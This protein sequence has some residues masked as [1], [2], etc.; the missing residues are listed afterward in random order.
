MKVA[1]SVFSMVRPEEDEHWR[2]LHRPGDEHMHDD[3]QSKQNQALA[4]LRTK[5]SNG[6]AR[7]G[8]NK[9]QLADRARLGRTTVWEAFRPGGPVPSASTV[10][11]LARVLQLSQDELLNLQ[12]T[13]EEAASDSVVQVVPGPGKPI[14][15]WD[16]HHLEVHPAVPVPNGYGSS[17]PRQRV[18]PGY[19]RRAHDRVLTQAVQDV[20]VGNSRTVVLVGTS[21][22]GKTRACWEAVQPLAKLGWR[23][24]HPLDPTRADAALEGLKQVRPSTVV[25]LNEAQHYLGDAAV[26]EQIA[27][28]V[29][30]L[31]TDPGRMPVLV[32]GTLWPE[33]ARRYVAL[34]SASETDLHSQVR[35]LLAGRTLHVPDSFDAKALSAASVLA[36]AGDQLLA[37]ALTRAGAHG[38]VTQDLAGAPEL[39]HAYE[40]GTP[41]ARALLEAAMDARRLGVGLHLPQTFLTDAASDYLSDTDYESLPE[42]WAEA[43]FAELARPVHG[44][45]APLRRIVVRPHRHP[46]GTQASAAQPG[47]AAGPDFRLADYL[48]QHGR[49]IRK[50]L[51]PPASFWHAG[52]THLIRPDDLY[53][54][55]KAAEDRLRL[56][57]AHHFHHRAAIA[58]HHESLMRLSGRRDLEGIWKGRQ[59]L[60]RQAVDAGDINKLL[61]LAGVWEP[62]DWDLSEALYRRAADAGSSEAMYCLAM[63]TQEWDQEGA[64]ALYRQA[65]DAGYARA[66]RQLAVMREKAGDRKNAEALARQAAD[67]GDTGDTLHYLALVRDAAGDREGAEAVYRQAADAG[68]SSTLYRLVDSAGE[69]GDQES[70][71]ALAW[72]AADAG[73]TDA[74]MYLAMKRKEAGARKSAEAL[75]RQAADAGN[76][77]AV[78][79]L[80]EL[81]EESGDQEGAEALARQA[82][83]AGRTYALMYLAMKRKEAGDRK[84]AEAF[85]RQA[86]DA[87]NTDAVRRLIELRKESGDQEGAE[88]LARQAADAG[89]ANALYSLARWPGEA[90][91][92][93]RYYG[94]DPDGTPTSPWQ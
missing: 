6:L 50:R 1:E 38:R 65:A 40:D 2:T 84:G 70:A 64:E 10:A 66:L 31:L 17:S 12:R 35:E 5:L 51:C 75:Y 57:W 83:D 16:P 39:L 49:T 8:L 78:Y 24:W 19:V 68:H 79:R 55:A 90:G 94:L 7:A 93:V 27:A 53:G 54:L 9:T 67:A 45:Q 36:E 59:A 63:A 81:R 28:T 86:A 47:P 41:A 4:E 73:H 61:Y 34:P 13:A 43:A 29:R 37:D 87:G 76:T 30:A 82:T 71:E 74:L 26:G 18:L 3:E 33:Y 20:Q 56:Q 52:H 42:D 44:R 11:A 48:E 60:Y 77:D 72:Q 46:P 32:L 22:T 69:S 25:W 91:D 89:H 80:I 58:G 85:Y 62:I 92:V 21:S 14:S 88:A 23:L 15:E